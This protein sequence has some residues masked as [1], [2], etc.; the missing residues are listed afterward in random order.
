MSVSKVL[1]LVDS[2]RQ[3]VIGLT[4]SLVRIPSENK[5][6]FGFEKPCQDFVAEIMEEA[7][8]EVDEFTPDEVP[9]MEKH[10]AYLPGRDY[11][12]R[13]NIVGVLKSSGN[14]R[15]LILSGHID[16]VP[17]EPL[18]WTHDP[19]SGVVEGTKLFGRG[20]C[21]QKAG[22]A[23][24]IMAIKCI[25]DAGVS[26]RGNLILE[27]VVDEEFGGVNGTLAC[28]LRGYQADAAIVTEPTFLTAQPASKGGAALR[29][30]VRGAFS[31]F[32]PQTNVKTILFNVVNPVKKMPKIVNAITRFEEI[33]GEE[34]RK[35]PL[36]RE[37]DGPV[38]IPIMKVKAGELEDSGTLSIP[39]RCELSVWMDCVHGETMQQVVTS[40]SK[41]MQ[42][43]LEEDDWLRDNPPTIEFPHPAQV[44]SRVHPPSCIDVNHPIVLTVADSVEHVMGKRP[45]I[46]GGGVSDLWAFNLHS[47][48]PAIDFGPGG[49]NAHQADEYVTVDTLIASTKILATA[50]LRWCGIK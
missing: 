5:P 20:A 31:G 12:N 46:V 19:F 48:T 33:R 38:P 26:L 14:G 41:F 6:P 17:K 37:I 11:R 40:F 47:K 29:I 10:P 30:S 49:G 45:R 22:I 28:I 3:D 23:A 21:D 39:S 32:H 35:H 18:P 1:E 44:L 13:P 24:M 27:S 2:R 4:Q 25:R 42:D 16:T 34:Q 36:Y 9:G 7:G 43:T 15:A 8:M 50:V